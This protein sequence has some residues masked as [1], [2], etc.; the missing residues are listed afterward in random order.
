MLAWLFRSV[1]R[2]PDQRD[3]LG[4]GM[5][6]ES[7]QP[8]PS[9]VGLSRASR[10]RQESDRPGQYGARHHRAGEANL[11][12]SVGLKLAGVGR[13]HSVDL[14][15]P[16]QK[17]PFV[18]LLASHP[19]GHFGIALAGVA[20]ATAGH[21][22]GDLVAPS[23]RD[24]QHAVLLERCRCGGAVRAAAPRQFQRIPLRIGEFV[25]L[26]SD[27][28]PAT[29][30]VSLRARRTPGRHAPNYRGL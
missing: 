16:Q 18:Q 2:R 21:D 5:G 25:H 1:L 20:R 24:G 12:S 9:L 22:V 13:Q 23:P 28:A 29:A 19:A 3:S 6:A 26:R 27:T 15:L 8:P 30:R 17:S 7:S 11:A 4:V 10:F 14:G